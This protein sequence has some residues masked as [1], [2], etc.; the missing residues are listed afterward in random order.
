MCRSSSVKINPLQKY[1]PKQISDTFPQ[2]QE[3]KM[4]P[5]SPSRMSVCEEQAEDGTC[6][7]EVLESNEEDQAA[8]N[9]A[10]ELD[11]RHG[12]IGAVHE[13]PKGFKFD[14]AGKCRKIIK[15]GERKHRKQT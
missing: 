12:I 10:I 9:D 5:I 1:M 3:L 6:L 2:M 14:K 13:C 15:F 11:T 8:Q 4:Q 7:G